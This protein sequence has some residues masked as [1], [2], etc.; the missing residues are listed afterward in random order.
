MKGMVMAMTV[1]VNILMSSFRVWAM[2]FII[3]IA[4][5]LGANVVIYCSLEIGKLVADYLHTLE[6]AVGPYVVG[7][8]QPD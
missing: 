5:R 3:T 6:D 7:Y 1:T 4:M 8:A 2:S